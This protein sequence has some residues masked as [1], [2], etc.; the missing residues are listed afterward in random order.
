MNYKDYIKEEF[1]DIYVQ[2]RDNLTNRLIEAKYN[3]QFL[4]MTYERGE[5][6]CQSHESTDNFEIRVIL[7]RIYVTVAWELALQIKAFTDDTAADTLTISKLQN[8]MFTYLKD[9]K[10]QELYDNIGTVV[11]SEKWNDCKKIVN[12]ISDY[13]NKIVGHNIFNPPELYFSIV[14]AEQVIMVYE[15]L[16]KVL[17]FNDASY[18]KR[19]NDIDGETKNFIKAYLDAVLPL[20]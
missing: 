1:C 13:R 16:F 2:E 10:K 18:I 8:K 6:Y 14:E 9:D 3:L 4:K 15:S 12:G 20:A 7:R 19:A 11:K 5:L 17:V